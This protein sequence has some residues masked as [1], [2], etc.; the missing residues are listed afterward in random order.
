MTQT[1]GRNIRICQLFSILGFAVTALVLLLA[2]ANAVRAQYETGTISGTAADSSGAALVGATVTATNTG[3]NIGQSSVTDDAGRYRIAGLPIGTYSVQASRTGFQRVVH[4]NITLTVGANLVVDFAL[5]VGQVEQTVNVESEVSRVET[6]TAAVSSLVTPQQISQLPLNGRNFEQLLSLAPGVQSVTQSYITGGGGG[7][8]SSGFYGP[9]QTYSVAGSRPVGQLFLLDDQDMQGYWNKGVGSNITGNSLGVEAIAEFQV[10]TNTYSAQYGGTGAAINAASKSGTNSYHG[11]LYEYVRNSAL[12]ARNFFDGS[13]IPAFNRNQFGGSL[14]G[15]VKQNKLF[16]FVNYEGVKS[17]LGITGNQFVPDSLSR[18]GDIP[19]NAG[20]PG[21]TP[22]N[23]A[24]GARIQETINPTMAP[25]LGLYPN[26]GVSCTPPYPR[27]CQIVAAGPFAGYPTGNALVT[28]I[29]SQP[30]SEN[31]VLGRVDYTIGAKDSIFGRYISDTAYFKLPVP[32]SNLALWPVVD[33]GGDQF[34]TLEEKHIVSPTAINAIRFSF[35]RTNE[36]AD[37]QFTSNPATDLLQFYNGAP[38]YTPGQREDGNIIIAGGTSNIGPGATA[39]FHLIENKFTGGDDFSWTHGPHTISVGL[40][41]TRI[42]DNIAV[43]REGGIFVF[44]SLYGFLRNLPVQF[45]G[46]AN[47]S[48]TFN[49]TRYSRSIAISPYIEDDWKVRSNLTLNIGLR[50]DYETDPVCVAVQCTNLLNPLTSSTFTPVRH[51]LASNPNAVNF[52]PRIGVAW[53]PFNNQNTSVRAG[54]GMF[55]EPLAARTFLN[56]YSENPPSNTVVMP[57][58]PVPGLDIVTPMFPNPALSGFALP[59]GAVYGLDYRSDSSPYE[60]Q[61]NLTVQQNIGRGMVASLGYVGAQGV[62]L[63][64]QRNYNTP[65]PTLNYTATPAPLNCTSPS[66]TFTGPAPNPAFVFKPPLPFPQVSTTLGLDFTAPTSHSSYNGLIASLTRQ[67]SK[68][69]QGQV[70]YTYS[71]CIDNGSASS[72]LEQGSFEVTDVYNQSYD[73]G[74]C[75]FNVPNALRVNSVYSL[76]FSGNRL[77]SGW[78]VSEILSAASGF[79]V[80]VLTGLTPTQSNTLGLTG[81]RPNHSGA[82]GCHPNEIVD[83]KN[84]AQR[85]VQWFNPA[86]YAIEPFGTLGNVGRNSLMG[87]GLLDLDFSILKQTRVTEKMN[88]EFRAEFFNIINRTNLG[89]PISAVFAGT[90]GSPA[91]PLGTAFTSATAGIITSTAT[92]SR[93]IQF[94]VKLTF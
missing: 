81:D 39:R 75:A 78:Q 44:P 63:Y 77:V 46:E 86:C 87:P 51:V 79:P 69:L 70:S 80:N 71:R 36:R 83:T 23:C 82:P 66:C 76:P 12:D 59:Y 42:Q 68:D 56:A 21:Q 25:Y 29:A 58:V 28:D 92:T 54:F 37:Q 5:P 45:Q 90:R 62:H 55:H 1:S 8:I 41:L 24:N 91:V 53:A 48:P 7:G 19:C 18:T 40:W 65:T 67:I 72:G 43:G 2:C 89:Q 20:P 13:Q 30:E 50:Y 57:G 73:R 60:I 35:S 16:F 11:S 61:Y 17:S 84:F 74:P 32:F 64:G 9:G 34:F 3:T 85:Y 6:Q 88:A 49:R 22:V 26:P 15:P 33:H 31:Y 52:D 14:G 94:A 38:N 4:T 10:L 27:S 93:Q 47:P